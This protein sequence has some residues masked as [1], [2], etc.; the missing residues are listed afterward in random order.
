MPDPVEI[1]KKYWHYGAFRHDQEKIIQ[2]ILNGQHTLA[3][4]PTGGGK[5]ICYQVPAL[6]LPGVALVVSPLIALMQD[7]TEALRKKG[8]SAAML[9]S[10]F[11]KAESEEMIQKLKIGEI[12]IL[13]LSPE[14]L[15]NSMSWIGQI[16]WSFVAVDEAHCISQWGYDFRPSYLR[17]HELTEPLKLPVLAL[18][19]TA[20]PRVKQ[21]ILEHLRMKDPKIYQSS[22]RRDNISISVVK[23]ENKP[24]SLLHIL[25]RLKGSALVYVRNRRQTVTVAR[26][27]QE[28]GLS[29]DHYH[30]GL[31]P[32]IRAAKMRLWMSGSCR[33]MCCTNA[34]G[35]GVDKSDVRLII[36]LDL[37]NQLEEYF[38]EAGRA[39]RDGKASWAVVLFN[40]KDEKTLI[41]KFEAS[42]LPDQWILNLWHHLKKM[43]T[44]P[45]GSVIEYFDL[46]SFAKNLGENLAVVY[47]GL[48]YLEIA[49]LIQLGEGIQSKSRIQFLKSPELIYEKLSQ[50]GDSDKIPWIKLLLRTHEGILEVP[51]RINEDF[52]VSLLNKSPESIREFFVALHNQKLIS[53]EVADNDQSLFFLQNFNQN[54]DLSKWKSYRDIR[55]EKLAEMVRWVHHTG[56]R[57]KYILEYFGESKAL[58]CGKCDNCLSEKSLDDSGVQREQIRKK[59]LQ[60]IQTNHGCYSSHI[61]QMFPLNR[62]PLV[63][64]ILL[65]LIGENKIER[66]LEKF[67]LK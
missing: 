36:H 64:Y 14:K 51:T 21:D 66:R 65:E 32:E 9:H 29:A 45:D 24:N 41:E 3:L 63:E 40:N 31:D 60:E 57:Q 50:S 7:Q 5:S 62:K 46:S 1:L 8:I 54:L 35:M 27:L 30:A 4:M 6:C 2:S 48:K 52:L 49:G 11:N 56:C 44:A 61:F 25:N 59:I 58:N 12:K 55:L 17:I 19:A 16:K 37:P 67:F 13:Y 42:D 39:G 38:Q 18:T 33:I 23:T 22:F 43:N 53:F 34:F 26:F 10:G 20:T 28:Q 15:L 47:S